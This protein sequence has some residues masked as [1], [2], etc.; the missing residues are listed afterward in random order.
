MMVSKSP[1]LSIQ[2]VTPA[3][4]GSHSGNRVTAVR[5][6]KLLRSL[7]HRVRIATS[8]IGAPD[9]LVALHAR[10]SHDSIRRFHDAHP[11]RPLIVT[12]TGTDLYRDI[13]ND[14]DAARSLEMATCLVVLQGAALEELPAGVRSKARV[15]RQS[16]EPRNRTRERKGHWRLVVVGHLRAEKDPFRLVEALRLIPDLPLDVV[17][18]GRALAAEFGARAARWMVKEPRYRWAGEVPAARARQL[19][20]DGDALVLSSVM[21]GGANVISEAVVCGVPILASRIPSSVALLGGDYEGY[22]ETE[23][24]EELAALIRRFAGDEAFRKRLQRHV[25]RLRRFFTPAAERNAW[26]RLLDEVMKRLGAQ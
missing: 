18:A 13:H 15:I 3:V 25:R 19:I 7:G 11:D 14:R 16:A 8:L 22:F 23:N 6:A 21:E 4:A 5:W 24:T 17:H 12:L 2:I 1:A 20:A 10:R 9:V 26:R